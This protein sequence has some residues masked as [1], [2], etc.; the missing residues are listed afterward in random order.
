ME[1]L[2][3]YIVPEKTPL[4]KRQNQE[5]MKVA[6]RIKA[7]RILALQ[8][9]GVKSYEQIKNVGMYLTAYL[10]KY[11]HDDLNIS[12]STKRGR[13]DV[14][15]RVED[16]LATINYKTMRIQDVDEDFC[17]GFLAYLRIAPNKSKKLQGGTINNGNAVTLQTV[18][19]GALNKA[20]RDGVIARNPMSLLDPKEKF[21]PTESTRE[22][23]TIEELKRAIEA[24]AVHEDTKKAFLFACF[25]GLRMS[26]VKA[27]TWRHV[28]NSSDGKSKFVKVKM[29]KTQKWI[30][31]PLSAEAQKWMIA[32]DDLD[33]PIFHFYDPV[34]VE[35]H[36]AIWMKNAGISKHVTFHVARHTFATMMLTLDVDLY[37]V[38]KLL[39][40]S[41]ITT[42]QIYAKIIDKKRVEAI[43]KLDDVFE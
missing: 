22:F 38:S 25:T 14:K 10:D 41:K 1:S 31:V 29:Q 34:N 43:S 16:Y 6:E 24:P 35:K 18:F 15:H 3:L 8:S 40:H 28:Q 9:H 23:L 33:E 2:G 26:D 42:T 19:T 20:V 11:E 12:A 21:H 27:L 32:K 7:E 39:G 37:T 30:Y 17:R 4:D 36:I 13:R 5:A